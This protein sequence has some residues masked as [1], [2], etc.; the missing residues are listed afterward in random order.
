MILGYAVAMVFAAYVIGSI[1]TGYWLVKALKGIDVRTVGSGSTGATNVLRAAGKPAALFVFFF[2]IFKGWLAVVLAVAFE[3][4]LWSQMPNYI[5]HLI[6]TISGFVAIF[7]HSRS[8]FLGFKGGKSAATTLGTLIGL[9][10][11]VAIGT[12]GTWLVVLAL[13]KIVS[14]AS[15]IASFACPISAFVVKAPTSVL[16]F[17]VFACIFVVTRHRSNVKRLMEGTEPKLG[18]KPKLNQAN[19]NK[20]ESNSH[21]SNETTGDGQASA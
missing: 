10:H 2:D 14:L 20:Q 6:P 3:E 15:I 4:Q 5:P 19:E 8:I 21:D 18:Q 7:G 9:N 16:I 1:P 12:F 11:G 13:S 17:C